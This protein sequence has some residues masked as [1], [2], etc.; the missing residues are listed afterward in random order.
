MPATEALYY[1]WIDI[2]D[3]KWLKTSILYWDTIRTIV[4]E[5]ISDPYSTS[6]AKALQDEGFLLPLRVNPEMDEIANLTS[7]IVNYFNSPEA[8][9]MLFLKKSSLIHRDKLP[10]RMRE[11]SRIHPEK[12]PYIIEEITEDFGFKFGRTDDWV[13]VDNQFGSFYMT[14]LA[15]RLS[16]RIGVSLLTP[17]S[18]SDRLSI[19]AKLDSPMQNPNNSYWHNRRRYREYDGWGKR[20]KFPGKVATGMLANLVVEKVGIDPKTPINKLIEFRRNHNDELAKLRT[21]LSKLTSPID[22]EL[23]IENL[24]QQISDLYE[25]DVKPAINDLESALKGSGIKSISDG[26]LKTIFLSTGS[27]SVLVGLGLSIPS[28]I[29]VGIGISLT[30]HGVNYN[31]NKKNELRNNPYSYLLNLEKS[32]G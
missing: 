13:E 6:T 32:F 16:E 8:Q 15:T 17:S 24:R 10:R 11:L 27:S 2:T 26:F 12:L 3:T 14:L 19:N 28:A 21:E 18:L 22:A 9:E 7:D 29:L 23:P 4:P 31:A 25:N 20:K 30:I 1:P 5:S